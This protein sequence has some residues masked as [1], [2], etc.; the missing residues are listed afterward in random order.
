MRE[1][2]AELRTLSFA[3]DGIDALPVTG[4]APDLIVLCEAGMLD[5]GF[6]TSAYLRVAEKRGGVIA[7]G[8]LKR[9][10]P[11]YVS[12]YNRMQQ[13]GETFNG[14]SFSFPSWENEII[15]PGGESDPAILAMKAVL[16]DVEYQERLGAVP[17]PSSLLVFGREFDWKLHVKRQDYDAGLP[18]WL[19]C[20]PGYAGAYSLLVVQAASSSEVRVIDEFYGRYKTWDDAVNWLL[21]RPYVR[22]D[23]RG[24]IKAPS[25]TRAVMDVAGRQHHGD[26]SQVEQ[27]YD[28]T[29]LNWR[30][31]TVP[32]ET[33][34]NRMRD[35]LRSPFDWDTPRLLIDPKCEGLLFELS[36]GEVYQKDR[37]GEP[38]REAPI[39]RHNH[40]R[41]ALS[42]LLVDAFGESEGGR[43]A[44]STPG[45]NPYRRT[46]R[47]V[48]TETVLDMVDGTIRFTNLRSDDKIKTPL[49]FK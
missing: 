29:G 49:R 39:D 44:G 45:R 42:Y 26:K 48:S 3:Q 28:A 43:E 7:T 19:A 20:D 11:W 8:T 32:I 21:H 15:Y 16:S 6:L 33:G 17:V 35:F 27:W 41:K 36:E 46:R 1:T 2:G 47:A 34:I 37:S 10:R 9:S 22:V 5:E 13:G 40:S 38:L 24:W 31:Q 23:G 30:G 12:L 4:K 14:R 18:L 25:I